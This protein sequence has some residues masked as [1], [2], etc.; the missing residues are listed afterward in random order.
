MT[1]PKVGDLAPG[2][3]LPAVMRERRTKFRLNDFRGIKHVVL[4]FYAADFTPT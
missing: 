2:F 1:V 3:E 4:A